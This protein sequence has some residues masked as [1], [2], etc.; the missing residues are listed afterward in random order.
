LLSLDISSNGLRVEET[1][2]LAKALESNKTMT[3]L[4]ISSNILTHDGK[5]A[6]DMPGVAALADVI[7][8]MGAMTSLNLASNELGVEGAEIIAACLPKCT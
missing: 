2:L 5:K 8:G 1:K 6:G 7:P 4:N 3:S